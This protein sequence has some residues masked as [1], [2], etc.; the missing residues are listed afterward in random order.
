M[1]AVSPELLKQLRAAVLAEAPMAHKGVVAQA[2]DRAVARI[3]EPG[4]ATCRC[5]R[6]GR[7]VVK[8]RTVETSVTRFVCNECFPEMPLMPQELI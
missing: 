5:Y 2:F 4:T 8:G 1:K 6:C 3:N 7:H